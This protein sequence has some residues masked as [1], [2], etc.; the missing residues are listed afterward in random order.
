MRSR[1]QSSYLAFK[2]GT[3][4]LDALLLA[5]RPYVEH[6]AWQDR[7][8]DAED[9]AQ[10][11]LIKVWQSIAS[12]AGRSSYTTWLRRV[13]RNL[14]T[15]KIRHE[16]S[17]LADAQMVEMPDQEVEHDDED[18]VPSR[19]I[20]DLPLNCHQLYIVRAL[21]D[22]HDMREIAEATDMTLKALQCRFSRIRQK[23]RGKAA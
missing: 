20:D 10:E 16:R 19:S 1:L 4:S 7:P 15:D 6:I 18:G 23:C 8:G 21:I 2:A 12:F 22:G 9:T 13:T 11:V 5:S 17:M 3:L 14:I